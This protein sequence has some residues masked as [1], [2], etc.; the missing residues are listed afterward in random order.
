MRPRF[1][2]LNG[3]GLLRVE[4]SKSAVKE[5]ARSGNSP[6]RV[7]SGVFDFLHTLCRVIQAKLMASEN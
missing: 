7:H 3:K 6:V 5:K 1:E 2:G 4:E